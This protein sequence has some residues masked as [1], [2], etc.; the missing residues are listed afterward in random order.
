MRMIHMLVLTLLSTA[1]VSSA[2]SATIDS[3]KNETA[4]LVM[5][6][7]DEGIDKSTKTTSPRLG[8]SYGQF[9][10]SRKGLAGNLSAIT[11]YGVTVGMERTAALESDP[12]VIN[13]RNNGVFF[14]YGKAV[15]AADMQTQVGDEVPN[16]AS[17]STNMYSFGFMEETGY[18]YSLGSSSK[19]KFLVGKSGIWTSVD[20]TSFDAVIS[21]DA[22]QMLNDFTGRIRFGATMQPAIELQIVKPLSIRAGYTWTQIYPRHMFWYWAGSEA[23]EGIADGL[24]EA[25]V[26]AFG[27]ASPASLPVMNF[28]LRNALAY[29]FKTLRKNQMNWPFDTAAPM[30]V[31]GWTV[32]VSVNF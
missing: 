23:L 5:A 15:A 20:P 22:R 3:A 12:S 14:N 25:S 19:L 11:N 2:A 7:F 24:V 21:A 29:G 27:K 16:A 32:G 9:D 31:Y 1:I 18:G 8:L 4:E 6:G 10:F 17:T 13:I 26:K 30:N 28:V